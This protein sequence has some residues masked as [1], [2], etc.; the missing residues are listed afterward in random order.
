M[1]VEI[2]VKDKSTDEPVIGATVIVKPYGTWGV[3][4][5][6]GCVT[7]EK[8]PVGTATFEI[9]ILGYLTLTQE[10]KIVASAKMQKISFS[11]Q[12]Q[13]LSIEKVTV[14]AKSTKTG[15]STSSRIDRQAISHLQATSLK[16]LMQL[17]PGAVISS[18]PSLTSSSYF[19]NRTLDSYD[20]NNAFGAAVLID[21]VPLSSNAD[22]NTK[23]GT[24]ATASSGTDLRSIGTDNIESVEIIRGIPSAEYGDLSSGM[25][26][27]NR[28][29]GISDLKISGKIYPGIIQV[30]AG[31][32]FSIGKGGS[33][34]IS[35]DFANG[36]SDPRYTTDTYMRFGASAI[37]SISPNSKATLTTSLSFNATRDWSG[38][39]PSEPVQDVFDSTNETGFRVSHSGR[40][41]LGKTIVNNLKYD[42]SGSYKVTDSKSRNLISGDTPFYD[43]LVEGMF[44]TNLLPHQYYGEG[45]SIG[46]P[47]SFFAKISDVFHVGGERFSNRFNVGVQYAIEG[48]AGTGFYNLDPLLPLSK[49]GYR[50]RD[51]SKIPALNT[52][53]AY[54]EDN[55]SVHFSS[56]DKYPMMTAQIGLRYEGIQLARPEGM[57]AFSPRIN[58]TISPLQW[59]DIR[60]G[61]G[62][63]SKAPSLLMLYPEVSYID[64][65]NVN[66]H[67]GGQY[68]GAYTTRILDHTSLNLRPMTSDKI[69]IGLEFKAPGGRTFS[70]VAYQDKVSNGFSSNNE[71]WTALTFDKWNSLVTIEGKLTYDKE[72]PSA[73]DTLLQ[74]ITRS[75][76]SDVHISR[77]IEWDFDLGSIEAS[78]TSFYF[79]GAYSTTEWH[80]AN[81][82]YQRPLQSREAYE[83]VYVVY[84]T[85]GK[86][87]E[88]RRLSSTLR[89]VQGIPAIKFVVS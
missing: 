78:H 31:K 42:I 33:L 13:S 51:F 14:V 28:K 37:H 6:K 8:I 54:I 86:Q 79:S 47:Y 15:E 26:L 67:S 64:I 83:K 59:M 89:V 84:D 55:I 56:K 60:I 7:F 32:G 34:N 80:S 4:D 22:M 58:A 52:L 71:E 41:S 27:V 25:M 44:D 10:I 72:H 81:K 76:N 46:K 57:S 40:F 5:G 50:P 49:S 29:N 68:V 48:N 9:S 17:L 69:E 70:I 82:T 23:G 75:A 73:R 66:L 39:D 11:L 63:A 87:N 16:D 18:N 2:A 3:T 35:G 30:A 53:S 62:R 36:K 45:G 12:E 85:R 1:P 88:K 77:G 19:T 24:V 20:S 38:P 21:G 74:C 65:T 61:Y 43:S